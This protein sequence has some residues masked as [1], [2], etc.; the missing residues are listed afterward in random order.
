MKPSESAESP[1]YEEPLKQLDITQLG[2]NLIIAIDWDPT[3]LHLRY[4]SN[5]ERVCLNLYIILNFEQINTIIV[6]RLL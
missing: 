5:R 3:A 1:I 4:Q 2:D 6:S